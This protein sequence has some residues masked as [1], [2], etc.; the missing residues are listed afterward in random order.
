MEGAFLSPKL[1][2]QTFFQ[3]RAREPAPP[4][5]RVPHRG[6]HPGEGGPGS[7]GGGRGRGGACTVPKGLPHPEGQPPA[8]RV[9]SQDLRG[10]AG[11][12][13]L[14][15]TTPCQPGRVSRPAVGGADQRRYV[16]GTL[17]GSF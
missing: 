5:S 2:F 11:G 4:S 8:G 16:L 12:E 1:L 17:E 13:P 9:S 14:P 7:P 6:L 15:M 10:M 3:P